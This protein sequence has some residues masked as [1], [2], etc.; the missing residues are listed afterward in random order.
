MFHDGTYKEFYYNALGR[1]IVKADA[2]GY[3]T[4]YDYDRAGRLIQ[5]IDAAGGEAGLPIPTL[6]MESPFSG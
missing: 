3:V 4:Q 2:N 6:P 5:V 1:K